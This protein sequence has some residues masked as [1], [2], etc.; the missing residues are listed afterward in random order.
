LGLSPWSCAAATASGSPV[1]CS[2]IW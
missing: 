1:T 2:L